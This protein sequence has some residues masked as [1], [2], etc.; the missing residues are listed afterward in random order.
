MPRVLELVRLSGAIFFRSDF[1]APWAYTS[2]PTVEL[3]TALPPGAGSLVMLH[4]IA[5]GR[6]WVALNDGVRH[7][8]ARGDVV[9]MPYGDANAWG[10]PEPAEPV[11]IATL[12]RPP[13]KQLPHLQYGGGLRRRDQRGLW[14]PPWRRR[15]VR[16][17]AAGAAA[18]VCR[19]AS[20]RPATQWMRASIEYALAAPRV[21]V[22]DASSTD[23]RLPSCCS[24]RYF[25]F[26][27]RAPAMAS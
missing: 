13:W 11:S 8:L 26:I 3:A 21:P 22:V 1:R 17:R 25:G 23:R 4:I 19:A 16:P 5:D 10:S 2:P 7:E 24:R 15:P 14:L 20:R 18:A 12:L 6:C 9:V 27:S